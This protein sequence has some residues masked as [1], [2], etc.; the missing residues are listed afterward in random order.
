[1]I[2][3]YQPGTGVLHRAH[4]FTTATVVGVAMVLTFTLPSPE[5]TLALVGVYVAL[6]VLAGIPRVLLPAAIIVAPV[7]LFLVLIHAVIGDDPGRALVFGARI[8]T[9]VVA[10]LMLLATIHPG[11][12]VDALVDR[13]V[14]FAVGYLL[15]ATL[16]A[17][18]RLQ[19]QGRAIL[20]AQRC[21]GLRVRGSLARR[22]RA[23]VPLAVPLVLA[24]LAE[25]DA[26]AFALQSRGPGGRARTAITPPLDTTR[27][28]VVRWGLVVVTLLAI[29]FRIVG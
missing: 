14:P 16:Q 18:P 24:A 15:A 6:A 9:M 23:I 26:R 22:V 27:D 13:G 1:M 2:V 10:F 20:D 4:P 12:L 25:V 8:T 28:R 17:V 3:G 29:V 5:G 7:W 21:R 11:R 19:A